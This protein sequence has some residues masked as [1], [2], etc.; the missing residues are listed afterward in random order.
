M[1]M[2]VSKSINFDAAH[3]LEDERETRPYSRMHG[4]SFTLAVEIEGEPDREKGWVVD[5]GDLNEAL[6]ALHGELDHRLLNEIEG[7]SRPTMENICL[8]VADKLR[9]QFP[10]LRRV[11]LSR[12]SIGETCVFEL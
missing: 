8:W 9:P 6:A 12:P 2:R 7:L 4:H 11:Q 1:P 10:N 5:F 3:F